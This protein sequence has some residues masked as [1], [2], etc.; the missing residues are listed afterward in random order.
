LF[1]QATGTEILHV[2]YRGAAPALQDV[3]SGQTDMVCDPGIAFPHIRSGKVKLL[4]I[5]SEKRSPFFPDVPTVGEQGFKGA[6]LD[7]WFGMWAPNHTSPEIIARLN[8]EIAKALASVTLKARYA[9]LGGENVALDTA[10]FKNL[11]ANEGK[12]LSALIRDQK[13]TLE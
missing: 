6:N 1:K 4:A 11:L 9:D 7:I 8:R 3:L 13:I 10:E 5:V 12:V 2:P